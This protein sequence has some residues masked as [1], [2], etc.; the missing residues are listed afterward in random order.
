MADRNSYFKVIDGDSSV[1]VKYFPPEGNGERLAIDEVTSFLEKMGVKDYDL[2]RLNALINSDEEAEDIISTEGCYKFDEVINIKVTSDKMY[3]IG[4]FY[5]PSKNGLRMSRDEIMRT[6]ENNKVTFGIDETVIDDFIKNPEYCKNIIIARGT[7][8]IEGAD[9]Y[10]TYNFQTDRSA[11][12]QL[13]EDGTVDFHHLNN[14]SNIKKGDVLAVLTKEDPGLPGTDVYGVMAKPRKVSRLT[15]KYGNGISVTEDGLKL[16]AEVD[17][18]ATLEKDK[19]FV[20]DN[21]DVPADVDNSTGD[22]N[23]S[24]S[25]TIKGNVRTGFAVE[26]DGDIEVFG[27]VEG[28]KLSAG[29]NIIL[30]RGI[31]GMGKS[32]IRA[33]GNLISKFIESANVNIEG[34]VETDTIINSNVSARGDIYVRGKNASLIGGNVRS[35]TLIEAANIGSAMG[36]ST[37]V[38]VGIDPGIKD[39]VKKLQAEIEDKQKE[40]EKVSQILTVMRKKRDMGVLEEE[41]LPMLAQLTK[42]IILNDSEIKT[43]KAEI[44]SCEKLLQENT[45]AKIR[46]T[47]S[48]YPGTKVTVAGDYILIHKEIIHSEFKRIKSEIKV[49]PL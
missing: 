17:G 42:N 1:S 28:C 39:K 34:Y 45:N 3:A 16:I 35:A 7:K 44:D 11:K 43:K 15:L 37:S 12:P 24:G 23:Y 38:E 31:Q 27:V 49:L 47:K 20:S 2:V 36:A 32:D 30:H 14:I 21:Y 8:P 40:N 4:R 10:I 13:N 48:I 18:H 6:I 5:P 25:V 9:A 29:G 33:K 26:A 19:V 41:K 46:V 22:I